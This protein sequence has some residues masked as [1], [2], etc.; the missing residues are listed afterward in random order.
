MIATTDLGLFTVTD[1]PREAVA[2][3]T[4]GTERRSKPFPVET[5]RDAEVP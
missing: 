1:S 2:N 4:A 5:Q 3:R